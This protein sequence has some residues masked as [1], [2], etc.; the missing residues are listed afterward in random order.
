MLTVFKIFSK[1]RFVRRL[2]ISN[3]NNFRTFL[4]QAYYCNE[5]WDQRLRHPILQNVRPEELYLELDQSFQKSRSISPVRVDIFA[6]VVKDDSFADE[7]L[8][9]VH[10]LRLTANT[11]NTLEST[12][13]AVMRI[14][15]KWNKVEDLLSALDDRLNYGLFL[16]YYTANLLLDT[17]WKN[18][19]YANG[20]L[21]SSF[22]M[23]QEE[24]DHPLT[25]GL[26]LLHCYK[27]LLNPKHWLERK[28]PEEP[29]EEIKVRVKYIRNPFDDDHFDLTNPDKI[30]GKTLAMISK[31][32]HDILH[33]SFHI[34][35]LALYD[36]PDKVTEYCKKVQ[37]SLIKEVIDLIPKDNSSNNVV[38]S[39]KTHSEDVNQLLNNLT[40]KAYQETSEKDISDQCLIF[41]KWEQERIRA[42]QLENEQLLRAK[43]LAEIE[44]LQIQ[45]KKKEEKLWFFENEEKIDF[46]IQSNMIDMPTDTQE[47][48]KSITVTADED[49]VPP[50]VQAKRLDKSKLS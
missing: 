18:E 38:A 5:V 12:T 15:L 27:Y 33:Q 3:Y 34:L 45:L 16:D 36:K 29:E 31:S 43:R 39:L 35:G 6:N 4:S 25:C 8:D 47:E 41:D 19:Q 7:L 42:F 20:A 32:K 11:G 49:Y 2:D 10:K 40:K 48:K 46:K 44:E 23:L 24:L 50:E 14:L 28:Q 1:Q 22:L 30:M 13:H 9:L 37:S 26:S 21:V 17:F